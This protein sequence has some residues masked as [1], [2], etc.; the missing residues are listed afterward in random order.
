MLKI[1]D[2]LAGYHDDEN[3]SELSR[4]IAEDGNADGVLLMNEYTPNIHM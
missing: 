4:R 2:V 1:N 3:S